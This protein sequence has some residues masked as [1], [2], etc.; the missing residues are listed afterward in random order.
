MAFPVPWVPAFPVIGQLL[1]VPLFLWAD[2]QRDFSGTSLSPPNASPNPRPCP[3]GRVFS[4]REAEARASLGA[5]ASKSMASDFGV[6]TDHLRLD[7]IR[8]VV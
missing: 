4:Q 7:P 1:C 2:R 8:S 5:L 3:Q 6:S